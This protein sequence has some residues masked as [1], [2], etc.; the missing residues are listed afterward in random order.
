[1]VSLFLD[2]SCFLQ[3]C[4][5]VCTSEGPVISSRIYVG[6][7]RLSPTDGCESA[8]WVRYNSSGCMWEHSNGLFLGEWSGVVSMELC[9]RRSALAETVAANTPGVLSDSKD[10]W[11]LGGKGFWDRLVLCSHEGEVLAKEIP[12]GTGCGPQ[13]HIWQ[14]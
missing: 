10:C 6:R 13:V 11:G 5:D 14:Q 1:M 7:E 3:P 2:S 9:Q 12:L 4:T 8:G